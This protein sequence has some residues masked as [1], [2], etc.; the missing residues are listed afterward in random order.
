[1]GS[2]LRSPSAYPA[3]RWGPRPGEPGPAKRRRTEEPA[4]LESGTASSL[5]DPAGPPAAGALTSVVVLAAGCAL[6]LPLDDVDLVLEPEPTSVLHVSLG[7]HNLMLV[8]EVLLG[9]GDEGLEGQGRSPLGLEPG[10]PRCA[11][12][13][14]VAVQQG[15]FCAC[16][17]E[18]AAQEE[19]YEEDL[20]PEFESSW[21]DPEPSSGAGFHYSARWVTGPHPYSP[22]SEPASPAP[23]PSPERRSPGTYF[24]LDFHL[25]EPFPSSPLQPLPPSPSPGPHARPQRPPG[26]ARKARRRLFQE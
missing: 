5:Q 4:D 21:M 8:P 25:L 3:P 20:D 26:P 18:I 16:V 11:L 10:T 12:R 7:D 22:I 15:F 24:N 1:M 6:Q 2:R 13:E 14:D 19:A 23:T 9:L 17:P